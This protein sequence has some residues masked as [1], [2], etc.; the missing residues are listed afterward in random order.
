MFTRK[1]FHHFPPRIGN[2][3]QQTGVIQHLQAQVKEV[4]WKD[5]NLKDG[6]Y[7]LSGNKTLF[8]FYVSFLVTCIAEEC[9]RDSIRKKYVDS[10]LR[11]LHLCVMSYNWKYIDFI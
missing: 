5:Q 3:E 8:H 10:N 11:I 4:A 1:I 6:L 2:P 7:F 9:G